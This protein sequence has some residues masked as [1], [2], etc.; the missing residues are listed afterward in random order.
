MK[1]GIKKRNMNQLVSL[2]LLPKQIQTILDR[3]LEG[4]PPSREECQT[5]LELRPDSLEAARLRATA[6]FV[7]RRRFGN[8]AI[9]LGQIGPEHNAD[10]LVEQLFLGIEYGCF[11]HAAM[12]RVYES[13]FAGLLRGDESSIRL[14]LPYVLDAEKAH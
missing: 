7:S 4:H 10:E 2:A 1:A 6:D 12:R 8:Q 14:D 11:Q 9:L 3:A 5:L 13:G